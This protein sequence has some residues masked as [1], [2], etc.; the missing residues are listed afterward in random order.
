VSV[1]GDRDAGVPAT[2]R[3]GYTPGQ[4]VSN[5]AEL[6]SLQLVND[7]LSEGIF[8]AQI[9]Y[10]RTRFIFGGGIYRVLQDSAID[11]SNNLFDQTQSESTKFGAKLSYERELVD[12]ITVTVGFDSLF[13][14]AQQDLIQTGR[15]WAPEVDFQSRA[16]FVQ[17]NWGLFDRLVTVAAG[18]RHENV[19]LEVDDYVTLA[20][21]GGH[22]VLGGSPTFKELLPNAGII[23]EPIENLR[24]YASYAEG[25]TVPDVGRVLRGVNV[26][27]IDVDNFLDLT[28]VISDNREIGVEMQQGIFDISLTHFWSTSKLGQRLVLNSDGIYDIRREP[29]EIKGL[30]LNLGVE[31]P[32]S[33]L[34]LSLGYTRL[35]G[36]VDTDADNKV[37]ADLDG[38]NISPDRVNLSADYINGPLAVSLQGQYYL[39]RSFDG[40]PDSADFEGYEIYNGLIRYETD[41]GAFSLAAYNLLNEYYVTYNS[42]TV[43]TNSDS[44]F[45]S[46]RGRTLT[47]GWDWNF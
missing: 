25:Y 35:S 12:D 30:E 17:L 15:Y 32:I 4:P 29:T 14:N 34:K 21:Y 41:Y 40:Q 8:T 45:Y 36:R 27:G 1:S 7:D 10:N 6:V 38:G 20:S 47:L 9:F 2:S 24:F 5:R 19:E 42:D 18:V 3:R 26:P 44:R 31:T 16:P 28:P 13:N 43:R 37:D 33:G 22:S 39:S 11:P 23:V 46:G